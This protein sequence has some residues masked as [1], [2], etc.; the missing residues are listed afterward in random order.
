MHH[1]D[2]SPP[3]DVRWSEDDRVTEY[4]PART[5]E[6]PLPARFR[7]RRDRAT[8]SHLFAD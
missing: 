4:F 3:Y 6:S 8:K 1:P 2:G 7:G 5:P